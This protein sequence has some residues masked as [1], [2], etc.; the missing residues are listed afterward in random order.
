MDGYHVATICLA[1]WP[2]QA[3]CWLGDLQRISKYCS[4]LGKFVTV[5]HYFRETAQPGH[6]DRFEPDRYKSP[7]LKQ[8]VIRRQD[9]PIS[10]SVRYW[11][12]QARQTI[13]GTM[14]ALATAV[15]GDAQKSPANVCSNAGDEAACTSE[16]LV[17]V[18][19]ERHS[20]A[21][22][23]SDAASVEQAKA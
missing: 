14:Q 22:R 21:E 23:L 11:Q 12:Q 8:A 1:H 2:G 6:I 16:S 5:E 13:A 7:Y 19:H 10:T 9:D 18:Q 20:A 17:T 4:A 3:S 15:S